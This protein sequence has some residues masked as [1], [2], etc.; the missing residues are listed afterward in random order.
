M[1]YVKAGQYRLHVEARGAAVVKRITVRAIPALQQAFYGSVPH[2]QAYGPHDWEMMSKDVL[3]N[4]NGMISGAA[5]KPEHIQPWKE[6]GLP[7]KAAASPAWNSPPPTP[8][9]RSSP[10]GRPARATSIR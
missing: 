6:A 8:S 10:L 5:P 2:I 9:T 3:P 4:V 7:S 1:R